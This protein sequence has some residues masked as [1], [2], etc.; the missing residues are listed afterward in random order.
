MKKGLR[1]NFLL[2]TI[3]LIL[4]GL[5]LTSYVPTVTHGL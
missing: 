5:S 3:C 2:P 4:I 1:E